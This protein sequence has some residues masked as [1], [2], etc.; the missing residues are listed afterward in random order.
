MAPFAS[1]VYPRFA[2]GYWRSQGR[3]VD[4]TTAWR[5]RTRRP[6]TAAEA[7]QDRKSHH[8]IIRAD[9][10]PCPRQSLCR[11]GASATYAC[12]TRPTARVPT[13]RAA[14]LLPGAR[15]CDDGPMN[16]RTPIWH[17]A[18]RGCITDEKGAIW[19]QNRKII[20]PIAPG[21]GEGYLGRSH[22]NS[23][24]RTP[25]RHFRGRNERVFSWKSTP[26]GVSGPGRGGR[27]RGGGKSQVSPGKCL[28]GYA[29]PYHAV[30]LP[31]AMPLPFPLPCRYPL[32]YMPFPSALPCRCP[33]P[34][35]AALQFLTLPLC[36]PLP[37]RH[38]LPS[39]RHYPLPYH[40]V[41]FAYPAV[42]L[43][44]TPPLPLPYRA[45]MP[46]LT[47]PLC[48]PLPCRYPLP[49]P[50]VAL[51][52]TLPLP[53]AFTMQLPLALPCCYRLPYHAVTLCL[54]LPLPFAFTM[55]L[56]F[57]LPCRYS[58]PLPCHCP[59]RYHA[60]TL[61]LTTPLPFAL[62]RR[63]AIPRTAIL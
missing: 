17:G 21:I 1:R 18:N 24:A 48:H 5:H 12:T 47:M 43:C 10:S 15:R 50:A 55:P 30:T 20:C 46:F 11:G 60:V 45:V 52:L 40:V 19:S 7:C 57:A 58:L 4:R 54:T 23:A 27:G 62:P 33:F 51:C 61:C 38:P 41:T 16:C 29:I 25:G 63:Y 31:L 49:Y 35:R 44:L 37:C 3:S 39:P 28:R 59:L 34:Y 56:P 13:V 53:L 8:R 36:H 42:T 22:Y 9:T 6:L 32:P 2:R 26:Q 14:S